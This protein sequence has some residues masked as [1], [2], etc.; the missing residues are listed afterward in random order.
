MMRDTVTGM[1]KRISPEDESVEQESALAGAE[2]KADRKVDELRQ[3]VET[4]LQGMSA[5]QKLAE[6]KNKRFS[7]KY[8]NSLI[9]PFSRRERWK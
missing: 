8:D 9:V 4:Q 7:W 5:G 6:E 2:S 1:R 3:V